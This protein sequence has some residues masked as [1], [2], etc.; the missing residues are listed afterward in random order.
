MTEVFIVGEDLVTQEIAE[1]KS[2]KG[3][4]YN[5]ALLPYI[6]TKW[7][8]ENAR[9]NSYSLDRTILRIQSLSAGR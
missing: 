1:G 5:S 9:K 3:R 2:C 8:A 6:R 4:E 7:N